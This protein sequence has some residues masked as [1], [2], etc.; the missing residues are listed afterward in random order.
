MTARRD[1]R[2]QPHLGAHPAGAGDPPQGGG[3]RVVPDEGGRPGDLP[4]R[5]PVAQP[6]RLYGDP[7]VQRRLE[8]GPPE[9]PLGA[10]APGGTLGEDGD[11]VPGQQGPGDGRDGFGQGPDPVAFDEQGPRPGGEG[12]EHR[13]GPDLALGQ[14]PGRQD[15][16]DERD[17]QPGDVVGDD[18]AA[19]FPAGGAVHG[20]PYPEGP[21]ERGGPGPDHGVAGADGEH[22]H[23][24]GGRDG[25]QEQGEGGGEP[26]HRPR[27]A[28]G[29]SRVV[30]AGLRGAGRRGQ[31]D[32]HAPGASERKWFR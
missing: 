2:E 12:A 8:G 32:A 5:Q 1:P 4:V 23:R 14:H 9:G 17:V 27:D 7:R 21:Q 11:P 6:H 19:P 30:R 31:P 22:P 25:E 29:P 18:Q 3:Q 26:E 24:C 13:P 15:R 20:D 16:R 28:R 10:P